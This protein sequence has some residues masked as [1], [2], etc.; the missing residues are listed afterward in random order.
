VCPIFIGKELLDGAPPWDSDIR[1][2]QTEAWEFFSN[3]LKIIP[4]PKIRN[5]ATF[6]TE[7]K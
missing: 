3:R 4:L 2:N 5:V 6:T 7:L 1:A